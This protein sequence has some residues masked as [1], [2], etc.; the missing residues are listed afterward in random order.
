[1]FAACALI[2]TAE[3]WLTRYHPV[4]LS[5]ADDA[6]AFDPLDAERVY[7]NYLLTC[8]MLGVEPVPRESRIASAVDP[9][10]STRRGLM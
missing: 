2:D 6:P 4:M 8:P 3:Y 9:R 7:R 10:Q 5:A 1:V